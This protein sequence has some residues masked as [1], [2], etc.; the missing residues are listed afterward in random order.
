MSCHVS[1]SAHVVTVVV[2][3][4]QQTVMSLRLFVVVS[5]DFAR[6]RFCGFAVLVARLFVVVCLVFC[7]HDIRGCSCARRR[8]RQSHVVAGCNTSREAERQTRKDVA[9]SRLF[10]PVAMISVPRPPRAWQDHTHDSRHQSPGPG[11][12]IPTPRRNRNF[13]ENR[14]A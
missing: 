7:H 9:V 3:S 2:C 12:R 5:P 4:V 13:S 10:G 6:K 14:V 1:R 8:W 11:N